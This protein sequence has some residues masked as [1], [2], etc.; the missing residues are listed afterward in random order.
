MSEPQVLLGVAVGAFLVGLGL[1][2]L[3]LDRR[4][5]TLEASRSPPESLERDES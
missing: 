3:W 4:L 1:Y 2:A 5:R